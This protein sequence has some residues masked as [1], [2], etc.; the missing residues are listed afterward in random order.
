[1]KNRHTYEP[2]EKW[3]GVVV[4]LRNEIMMDNFNALVKAFKDV[5]EFSKK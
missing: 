4:S 1:M 3:S 2:F 5:P